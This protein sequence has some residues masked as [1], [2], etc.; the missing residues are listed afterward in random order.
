MSNFSHCNSFS[1]YVR[2][3]TKRYITEILYTL[4]SFTCLQYGVYSFMD[5]VQNFVFSF[6]GQL[7]ASVCFGYWCGIAGKDAVSED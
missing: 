5:T 3:Q 7:H 6:V 4:L 1:V 2:T